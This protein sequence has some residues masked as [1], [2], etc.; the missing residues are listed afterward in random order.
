MSIVSYSQNLEDVLLWRALQHIPSGFYIDVG[1]NDPTTDSVTRAFY[2]RGWHG[3]NIEP[4]EQ[5]QRDLAHE[6]PRD[7]NLACAAGAA[8]GEIEIWECSVR[9]WATGA[10]EVVT[11]HMSAGHD[12]VFRKVPV[13]PLKEI[14]ALYANGEIHFLKIDVEGMEKEVIEGMDFQQFRPWI[15]LIEATRPNSPEHVH[16]EWEGMLGNA[17]YLFAYDDGLNRFYVA[18]EHGDL[19]EAFRFPPNVFDEYVRAEHL[20]ALSRAT[21]LERTL[22]EREAD[23]TAQ[24]HRAQ[25]AEARAQQAVERAHLEAERAQRLDQTSQTAEARAQQAEE[26]AYLEAERARIAE[27]IALTTEEHARRNAERAQ[28]LEVR[29]LEKERAASE[30]HDRVLA[31]HQSTSWRITKPL[32]MVK[33]LWT[34]DPVIQEKL[35]SASVTGVKRLLKPG[36]VSAVNFVLARPALK[37]RMSRLV[38]NHYP[39]LH[40]RLRSMTAVPSRPDTQMFRVGGV[41]LNAGPYAGKK[42]AILAPGSSSGML[43]GAER[44]YSGLLK[45]FQGKGCATELICIAVDESTFENIQQG[46]KAFSDLDLS[47]FD[48]VISTKAPTYA[49]KHPNHVLYLVHTVRVFYD[50]FNEVFPAADTK[51]LAQREWIHRED[52]EALARIGRRFAIGTEVSRRLKEWNGYE[53]EV[54]HPPMDLSGLH[55]HGI[56]DYFFMPGRLHPWKR[57]DLAIRAVLHSTLPLRLLISGT[58]EAES[59]L[60]ELA[61]NDARIQFLG[62]VDDEQLKV[63]YAESLAVPFLP[64]REDYG[65]VTLEAFASGKAVVTCTDSGEPTE[66]VEHGVTGLVCAPKPEDICAAFEQLWADRGL[67]KRL[68]QAGRNRIAHIRWPAVA[69]RLLAAG[70]DNDTR[71][72]THQRNRVRVAILDMQPIMPAVGGGRLRLLGLYHALGNNIEARYVGT[73]DWLGEPYRRHFIT[74]TLEEIDVPLSADHHAAAA[75]A[76]KQAGGRVVIDMVFGR[77]AHLSP[78]YLQETID[79]VE[80]A[81][82]VVFSHPWVAP[83]INAELLAGK[84]IV[85]D[86]HNVEKTLREQ[87]LDKQNP[88]EDAILKDVEHAERLAGDRADLILV[89]SDEDADGFARLYNWHRTKMVTI[90]NGVF[91]QTIQPPSV[92]QKHAARNQLG[93]RAD[94]AVAFFIGSDYSPNVEAARIITEELAPALPQVD[95]VIAGGVCGRLPAAKCRNTHLVGFVDDVQKLTWLHASDF[96]I[97]PMCSGSGTNIKMFD[98]MASALPIV[99][100]PIGARGIAAASTDGI[101]IVERDQLTAEVSK[102]I[103]NP[104]IFSKGGSENRAVVECKYSWEKI[105]PD[106]GLRLRSAF[107]RKTGLAYLSNQSRSTTP[108][109]AHLST[110]GIKCGIAEYT[111]KIIDIYRENG[112][113]NLILTC[114]SAVESPVLTDQRAKSQ[115][116]W[117]YDNKTWSSSQIKP[118]A[119][120]GLVAWGATGVLIQYHPAFYSADTLLAF[121]K[122]CLERGVAV[123]VV[124]HI[125]TSKCAAA[126]RELNTLGIVAFSHR[127]SEIHAA[128]VL[129]VSLELVPLGVDVFEPVRER[130]IT[131]R[132]WR[133]RPPIIITNGFLRKHKGARHL[134]KAMPEI[135][136]QFPGARLKVQCSL[137]PSRDS[138]EE[139]QD[140]QTE[141]ERNNLA[142]HVTLDTRFLDKK[143]VLTELAKA[144]L[145]VLPYDNNNEGGSASATDAFAVGL[146]VVVSTAE[147]FDGIR[148]VVASTAPTPDSLARQIT[149]ILSCPAKYRSL[150]SS[151]LIYARENSWRNVAGAFLVAL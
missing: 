90:P 132:D 1:A 84:T 9:G 60:R 110:V 148:E 54:L 63:L 33:R 40:T 17:R 116:A 89:C 92:E 70:F 123:A 68:G 47:S 58:G 87:I 19:L 95:F 29:L 108:R 5:H 147:I 142:D 121:V 65:Y 101:R 140:C 6:R 120:S 11:Q 88:F 122:S 37:T 80:W 51:L 76:A 137:Y 25:V 56:G 45:A 13:V 111:K 81:D 35:R 144:D 128:A 42:V 85:Y 107:L 91:G 32:R 50:M 73:Y 118:D 127:N 66:F 98:F 74:P 69:E 78:D 151:S 39:R 48:L 79:A 105:S 104:D 117:Y 146:P 43:G 130:D 131:G 97:N 26:R 64:L 44:F 109:V 46:Y 31:L 145:A 112:I 75:D 124:V 15:L 36:V 7:I 106:L 14:C 23:A 96:A 12:G 16:H 82:V 102:L 72:T 115:I 134:I 126:F 67:A 77:Q 28:Q 119:I 49:V 129:G 57:V 3:I 100:T 27:A 10:D 52:S 53:A 138:E 86:S 21:E 34:G 71:R 125:F 93:L 24:E 139:F 61:G 18:E 113:E 141:I 59:A 38:R 4:L 150:A 133:E 136:K 41:A 135:L 103:T 114:E 30:W 143:D 99:T 62:R 8:H 2:E 55:D 149:A 83:L 94:R 22:I 20:R